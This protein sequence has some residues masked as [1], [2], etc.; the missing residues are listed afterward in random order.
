MSEGALGVHVERG[1][2][3]NDPVVVTVVGEMDIA[4]AH[5]LSNVL[6]DLE[7]CA[8]VV[9][10]LSGLKYMDSS[11][12]RVV[13]V[14]NKRLGDRAG[15]VVVAGLSPSL[16]RL[17]ELAGIDQILAVVPGVEDALK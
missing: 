8:L 14:F 5:V 17:F 11:G 10:D 1:A 4:N 15:R 3:S 9:L 7:S 12:L 13:I 6:S 16:R 2:D